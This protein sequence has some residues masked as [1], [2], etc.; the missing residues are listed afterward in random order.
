[1]NKTALQT[2]QQKA[3]WA[4]ELLIG[5]CLGTANIIPGVS[6]GT[7][8]LVFKLY[9]RVFLI[10]SHINQTNMWT[11]LSFAFSLVFKKN[12]KTTFNAFKV[13]LSQ[14]DF[15][16]LF[17]LIIG[18][19]IAII[20]LS[21]LMEYLIVH[22]YSLTYALFF[23]LILVSIVIPVKMLREKKA[24]WLIF[25]MAGLLAT[26]YVSWAVNPY[27]KVEKKSR[28]FKQQY[29]QSN[30]KEQVPDAAAGMMFSF[31]GRYSLD[32]YAYAALCG[33]VSIS[34]MVLPGI[35]G[36]LVL[37]LMGQ[38]FE[39][40]SAISG[41]KTLRLDNIVFLLCFGMGLVFGGLLFAKL[42][43]AVLKRYYD[44]TMALLIGLMT[45]SLYALWP[46]KKSV[47][48]AEQYVKEDG[49][50]HI[51]ENVRVYTNINI[52]PPIG[53]PFYLAMVSAIA[54]GLIMY[55]FVRKEV[56]K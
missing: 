33:A 36:S 23:G 15:F 34:A 35:S 28:L 47:V 31:Q 9:E 14:K 5:Y 39:V 52:F 42:V 56:D 26:V 45:G 25:F 29:E 6:G 12:R 32:E 19:C 48:M 38:Y 51:V 7:F 54:G 41:L 16:F 20:S 17:K 11:C 4:K 49:M 13:F 55:F 40:V 37:I 53:M 22:H 27:D 3:N 46:F 10:L 50:I 44:A 30:Q 43:S 18:A 2:P 1:M 24:K 8:L 21:S